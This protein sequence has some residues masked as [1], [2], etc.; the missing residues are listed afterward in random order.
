MR[1][2]I[3][4]I[5]ENERDR[6]WG[7]TVTTV[8]YERIAPGDPYP[9]DCHL[10]SYSFSPD[11]GRVLQEYQLVYVTEGRGV[12]RSAA[13]GTVTVGA[14]TIFL[15]FPD[16]WHTYRPDPATGWAHYWIGFKGM[17]MDARVAN[18]FLDVRHP[19]FHAGTDD[20]IVRMYCKAI[21]VADR[22]MAN[23]QQL[24]AGIAN[25]L[26]G[27]TYTIDR[28]IRLEQDPVA[29]GQIDQARML[30]HDNIESRLTIQDIAARVGIGYSSFRR[31]FKRYTG[32]SP[33]AY[34]QDLKLQ[35]ARD[36]LRTTDLPVKEIS[37]RLNF[38]SP[39]YFSTLF[40]R[41]TGRTPSG[42][43]S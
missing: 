32:M 24:L 38:D 8:G 43:R 22:R 29:V 35:R 12:F 15:L 19:V 3:E 13:T 30:M 1:R 27:L 40:R 10:D 31:N 16:Q 37:Y 21:D 5:I 33:A 36:L 41:K 26:I 7:L 14:G 4:Y 34:F 28:N 20:E 11:K 2:P 9:S 6:L 39:D 17:N 23:F 42:F 18:G 25:Y